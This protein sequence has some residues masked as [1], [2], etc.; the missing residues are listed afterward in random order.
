MKWTD[1]KVFVAKKQK[2]CVKV[3]KRKKKRK[4][5]A[6][7]TCLANHLHASNSGKE[8]NTQIKA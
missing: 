6:L 8:E 7:A 1:Q 4:Q 3:Y 5:T 2:V